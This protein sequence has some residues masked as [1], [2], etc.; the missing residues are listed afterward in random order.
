MHRNIVI[1]VIA[2]LAWTGTAQAAELTVNATIDAV[3]ARPGDGTCATAQGTCTLRAAVQEADARGG[4]STITV[5]AGHYVLRIAPV[6]AAGSIVDMDASNGDLDI[7][8]DIAITGAGVG[9]TIV[10]GGGID[11]VFETGIPVRAS[12]TDLTVTGGDST[13]G[14]SQE[15]DLGG[16]ILNKGGLTL[17]RVELTGNR[18]DGGGGMFTIPQTSPTIRDSLITNNTATSGGGLRVD[19][20]ATIINTTISGNSLFTVAPADIA[21]K[22][23]G[24]AVLVVDEISGWGGGIDHRGGAVLKIVNSTIT[25]NTAVKGG[26]GLAAGQDYAPISEDLPLG[27]VELVN[28]LIAGNSST[29]GSQDCRTKA[30]RF[31]SLGHNLDG[32]GSCFFTKPTDLAR[33]DP[34]LGPLADNGGP[35]RTRALL[36]G[37]PAIDAG[38]A[39][40]CPSGDQRGI[41]R[42]QGAAC[43]IGAYELVVPTTARRCTVALPARFR[44]NARSYD[45]L[46][47]RKL[48][49]VGRS[50]KVRTR[51]RRTTVTLRIHLRSGRTVKTSVRATCK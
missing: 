12:F 13:A 34:H 32:D 7:T 35:T 29:A 24:A 33:G 28:T 36:P 21:V 10:D 1:G 50:P 41:P 40:G 18:A 30:V 14:H 17:E 51:T 20:G 16:G 4:A 8:A 9:K 43:D 2:A 48:L 26:G 3:D 23:A 37:S 15:I 25:D 11:R 22:P 42:P 45:V 46:S 27:H 5:P 39:D 6:P 38:A 49:H 47:G 44:R 19:S 31:V